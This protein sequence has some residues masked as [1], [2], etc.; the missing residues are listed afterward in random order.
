MIQSVA[1]NLIILMNS[2]TEVFWHHTFRLPAFLF[3]VRPCKEGTSKAV[4]PCRCPWDKGSAPFCASLASL[5]KLDLIEDGGIGIGLGDC[6]IILVIPYFTVVS[7]KVIVIGWVLL[8][9]E[10]PFSRTGVDEVY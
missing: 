8:T 9:I 3:Y 1:Y 6:A 4:G 7:G 2:A 5:V 10:I